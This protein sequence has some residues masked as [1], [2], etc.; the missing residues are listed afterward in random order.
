M[1]SSCITTV[2]GF[3]KAMMKRRI[4]V[5]TRQAAV[6]T[7]WQAFAVV[8]VPVVVKV[9]SYQRRKTERSESRSCFDI[10]M[11]A[12]ILQEEHVIGREAKVRSER[13]QFPLFC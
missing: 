1:V 11:H 10:Y 6:L 12:Y 4:Q 9:T 8:A 5:I 3:L 2:V 13:C 7:V